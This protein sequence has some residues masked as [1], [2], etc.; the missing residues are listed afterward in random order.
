MRECTSYAHIGEGEGEKEMCVGET[1]RGPNVHL[2][3]CLY[4][5]GYVYTFGYVY[6]QQNTYACTHRKTHKYIQRY[7]YKCTRTHVYVCITCT[8]I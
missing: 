1:G 6:M 7:A 5:F 2:F 3:V 4:I 8:L